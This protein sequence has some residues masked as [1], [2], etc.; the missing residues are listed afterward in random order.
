VIEEASRASADRSGD[1]ERLVYANPDFHNALLDVAAERG[2]I[3]PRRLGN[4]L[5]KN[6]HK[7]VGSQRLA[8]ATI[9]AGSARWKLEQR[10][11]PTGRRR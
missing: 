2:R 4:W 3:S 5:S 11:T 9:S 7:V 6:K 1:V 10:D 8:A